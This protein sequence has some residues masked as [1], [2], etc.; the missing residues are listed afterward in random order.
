VLDPLEQ[1][2]LGNFPGLSRATRNRSLAWIPLQAG[3][4]RTEEAFVPLAMIYRDAA[5]ELAN[6]SAYGRGLGEPSA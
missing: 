5:V 2:G 4:L 3:H 6:S 1:V